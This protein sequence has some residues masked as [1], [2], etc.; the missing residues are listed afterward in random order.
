[1]YRIGEFSKLAKTTVKTLRYYEREGILNPEF[2]DENGYRY[3]SSKQLL[4]LARIVHLRQCGLTIEDI[5]CALSAKISK[6]CWL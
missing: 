1:M 6:A 5:K 3:Y 4:E 2:V